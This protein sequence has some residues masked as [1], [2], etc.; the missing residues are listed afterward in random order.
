[1]RPQDEKIIANYQQGES[2]AVDQVD[3]WI[4]QAGSPYQWKLGSQWEE[5][6]Q[7]VHAK[8]TLSFQEGRFR[9][10]HD[11][12][13]RTFIARV[14]S[15]TCID[16]IRRIRI[17]RLRFVELDPLLDYRGPTEDLP[18]RKLE[19]T[20]FRESCLCVQAK[21]PV[22]D[23]ELWRMM[24]DEW[25]RV[26][27]CRHLGIRDGA[28]RKRIHDF[29][30]RAGRIWDGLNEEKNKQ[31]GNICQGATSIDSSRVEKTDDEL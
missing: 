17:E 7:D 27:M 29:R 11:A 6:V 26:E 25:D 12:S 21:M 13:L 2:E 28:L 10:D 1:M 31:R 15:Y 8:M 18:D 9:A 30:K 20:E 22:E 4:R 3:E 23:Q 19:E 24:E 5:A 16:R 14:T